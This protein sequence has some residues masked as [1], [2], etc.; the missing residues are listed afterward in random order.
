MRNNHARIETKL[1]AAFGLKRLPFTKDADPEGIFRTGVLEQAID[2]LRYL[3]D[4]RGIGVIFGAPGT[5]KSTLLRSFLETLGKTTHAVCY[6]THTTCAVL[7]LYRE[8]ARGF[9]LEPS[10]RKADVI[11]QI[12]QQVLKLSRT[13]KVRPILVIDEGHLLPV[14]FLDEIRLLCSFDVDGTDDLTVILA[15]HAQLE[16]TLRLAVNEAL[17]QRV[18]IR[19]RLRSLQ[20]AEVEEYLDYRLQQ[21]GRTAKLFLP[22]ATEAIA[23]ASRGIPRIVDRLA[24]QSLLIALKARRKEVDAEI[25]T[26]ATDEVEP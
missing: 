1:R 7:D 21:A 20:P 24:E 23:K 9:H 19:I 25:V 14:G 22:E 3:V 15:G 5:G 11:A 13:K 6:V 16:N 17:T 8:I 4:R 26:E 18:V 12:Q 10:C 2:R